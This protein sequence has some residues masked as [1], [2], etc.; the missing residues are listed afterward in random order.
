M[1]RLVSS[2][3]RF[4]VNGPHLRRESVAFSFIH[5]RDMPLFERSLP[6]PLRRKSSKTARK[7]GSLLTIERRGVS[8]EFPLFGRAMLGWVSVPPFP[9]FS[10]TSPALTRTANKLA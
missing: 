3:S 6:F 1:C 9:L 5:A 4:G 10:H 7:I 2:V 8:F